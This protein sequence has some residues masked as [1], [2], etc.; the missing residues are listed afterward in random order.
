[1]IQKFVNSWEM[2]K[3][4]LRAE[5]IKRGRSIEYTDL[6]KM[7]IKHVL[8]HD[9]EEYA[10]SS[11][12]DDGDYQGTQIFFFFEEDYQ[13]NVS[14]YYFTSNY[15]GSCSGCDTLQGILCR[16]YDVI[17]EDMADELMTLCLHLLQSMKKLV[18]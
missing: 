7:I 11:V 18:D 5:I 15:Y 17:T 10:M 9:D 16:D 1:M 13:P 6:M 3:D 14:D 12:I 4:K 8:N 2:N